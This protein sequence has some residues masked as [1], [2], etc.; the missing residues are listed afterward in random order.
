MLEG[1]A[2]GAEGGAAVSGSK[3]SGLLKPQAIFKVQFSLQ[4]ESAKSDV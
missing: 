4:E 3:D 2:K 1:S